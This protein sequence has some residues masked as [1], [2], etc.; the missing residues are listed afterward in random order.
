MLNFIGVFKTATKTFTN[1]FFPMFT[2]FHLYPIPF[3][4][5]FFCLLLNSNF[6]LFAQK[7]DWEGDIFL[8]TYLDY[9]QVIERQIVNNPNQDFT[10]LYNEIAMFLKWQIIDDIDYSGYDA[11][12]RKQVYD[13]IRD[14]KL[15]CFKDDSLTQ[16]F[17]PIKEN[18]PHCEHGICRSGNNEFV[19]FIDERSLEEQETE[20]R[21]NLLVPETVRCYELV[22]QFLLKE[23][24]SYYKKEHKLIVELQ[25]F[26]PM[27]SRNSSLNGY[28]Q[29]MKPLFWVKMEPLFEELKTTNPII[30]FAWKQ[31]HLNILELNLRSKQTL[32]DLSRLLYQEVKDKKV[33]ALSMDNVPFTQERWDEIFLHRADTISTVAPT[34]YKE[35]ITIIEDRAVQPDSLH[36]LKLTQNLYWDK[37][38]GR[39]SVGELHLGLLNTIY[40]EEQKIKYRFS[41]FYIKGNIDGNRA[42]IGF[43]KEYFNRYWQFPF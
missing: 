43:I 22:S 14:K 36:H 24:L 13:L 17:Y 5:I 4:L 41:V 16:P 42:Q 19:D 34:T 10:K 23:H 7:A 27:E 30:D 28:K 9:Q 1:T 29:V 6:S 3:R 33:D 31:S 2:L 25:A 40:D 21:A 26:A 8:P 35:G 12:F 32:L 15:N 18:Y 39:M 38:T 20:L 37:E 11:I